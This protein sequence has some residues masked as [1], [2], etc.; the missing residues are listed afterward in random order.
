[1]P[2]RKVAAR[3]CNDLLDVIASIVY[4]GA[5]K[6]VRCL[7]LYR[8]PSKLRHAP[9]PY[10]GT[11]THGGASHPVSCSLI[12]GAERDFDDRY[13]SE[14]RSRLCPLRLIRRPEADRLQT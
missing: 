4:S 5:A 3:F 12:T 10:A 11:K 1:M 13:G 6:A 2:A 14:R 8:N 9:T 7:C